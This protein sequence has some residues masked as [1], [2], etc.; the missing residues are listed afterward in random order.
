MSNHYVITGVSGFIGSSI[1]IELLRRNHDSKILAVL[2]DQEESQVKKQIAKITS[3]LLRNLS[4][5]LLARSQ[6]HFCCMSSLGIKLAKLFRDESFICF[7]AAAR[8]EFDQTLIEGRND[9]VFLTQSVLAAVRESGKCHR[10]VHFS[11]AFVC[12]R[13]RDLV[14][15][16]SSP[17]RFY[18]YYEQTKYESE[19]VVRHSG[20]DYLIVRPSIVVGH[21]QTGQAKHFRVFYGMFRLWLSGRIPRAPLDP[22]ARVDIVPIDYVV[23]AAINLSELKSPKHQVYHLCAGRNFAY[24]RDIFKIGLKVFKQPRAKFAPQFFVYLLS[25]PFIRRYIDHGLC[26]ILETFKGHFPY[27]GHKKREFDTTR[28]REALGEKDAEAPHI[29]KYGEQLFTY[30]RETHWG[31]KSAT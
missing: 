21:S 29:S 7:H 1:M 20:L 10:F 5:T 9:N 11:T 3:E 28:I 26:A 22:G 12:G 27:M 24:P 25:S 6:I 23:N 8:T 31:K 19:E 16:E 14:L 30:C 15:E 13:N 4:E 17:K 18:N 2:R